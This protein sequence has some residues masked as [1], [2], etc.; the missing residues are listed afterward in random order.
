MTWFRIVFMLLVCASVARAGDWPQWLG[1]KRDGNTTEKVSPWKE[2]EPPLVLWRAAVG[3]AYSSPVVA[4]GRVFLHACVKD[5]EEELVLALDAVTGKELWRDS[6]ARPAFRS[7]LGNGPRATP[8]VAGKRLYTIGINGLLSCYEV[9]KGKR[10]WQVDLYR[11]L[12]ADLPNFAVC[13]SPL[14]VGNRVIVSVGGKGR[15][16]VALNPRRRGQYILAGAVRRRRTAAWGRARR[17][18]HDALATGRPRSSGRHPTLGASDGVPTP[19]H[20]SHA[21]GRG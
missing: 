10:L 20:F 15:C 3:Q 8:T 7:V 11:Q 16:V 13:C 14:V 19:G 12:K 9:E 4:G 17:R 2:K 6:Y 5:K 1:P 21:G 18:L